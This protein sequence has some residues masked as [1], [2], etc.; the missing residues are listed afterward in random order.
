MSIKAQ[1]SVACRAKSFF[2]AQKVLFWMLQDK[3]FGDTINDGTY[4]TSQGLPHSDETFSLVLKCW[5]LIGRKGLE[6]H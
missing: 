2:Y 5:L 6:S 3:C 4:S 1:L